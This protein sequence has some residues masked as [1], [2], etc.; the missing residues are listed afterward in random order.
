[1]ETPKQLLYKTLHAFA[2]HKETC[3]KP[4]EIKLPVLFRVGKE[5]Y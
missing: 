5:D 3:T 4:H 2:E 1:M